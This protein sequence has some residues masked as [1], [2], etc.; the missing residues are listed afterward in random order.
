[1][2]TSIDRCLHELLVHASAQRT[3]RDLRLGEKHPSLLFNVAFLYSSAPAFCLLSC[4]SVIFRVLLRS[5]V[6]M[7]EPFSFI[8]QHFCMLQTS[9]EFQNEVIFIF[10]PVTLFTRTEQRMNIYTFFNDSEND[11]KPNDF[12]VTST[13]T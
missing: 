10:P 8:V 7:E 5:Q 4:F 6:N 9:S 2:V 12:Q 1:M 11:L 3:L 13:L